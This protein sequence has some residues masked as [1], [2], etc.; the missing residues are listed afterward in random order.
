MKFL[1]S[2]ERVDIITAVQISREWGHGNI[3]D[4][5]QMAWLLD[6]IKEHGFDVKTA[7][8]SVPGLC[9]D[10]ERVGRLVKMDKV[11]LVK[12]LSEY[13]GGE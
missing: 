5:L 10:K 13:I 4:R 1:N 9:E 12:Q 3:I 7:V 6:L 11:A 2:K 8:Q